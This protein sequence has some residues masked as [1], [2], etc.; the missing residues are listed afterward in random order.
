MALEA[1]YQKKQALDPDETVASSNHLRFGFRDIR[2][3]K[4]LVLEDGKDAGLMLSLTQQPGIAKSEYSGRGRLEEAKSFFSNCS[5]YDPESGAILMQMSGLRFAKLDTG[6]KPDPHTFDNITWKPDITF[7]TQGQLTYLPT[8][9]G[10]TKTDM[11]VDLIT[12]KMPVL[13]VLE[14]TFDAPD[15]SCLWFEAGDTSSR[16]A[17]FEYTFASADAKSL[18]NAQTQH[19]AQRNS[20]FLMMSLERE[21]FGLPE[22]AYDLAI[23]KVRKISEVDMD[24]LVKNSKMLISD[25]GYMLFVQRSNQILGTEP[26]SGHETPRTPRTPNSLDGYSVVGSSTPASSTSRGSTHD[27]QGANEQTLSK[28]K[29]LKTHTPELDVSIFRDKQDWDSSKLK[30]LGAVPGVGSVLDI[31]AGNDTCAFLCTPKLKERETASSRNLCVA[32]LAKGTPSLTPF[33]RK[34]LQTSGWKMTEQKSSLFN[35]TFRRSDPSSRRTIDSSQWQALKNLI[36]SGSRLLWV[37]NGAQR[38]IKNPDNALAHG[39]FRVIRME[40]AN[41]KLTTLDVQ[42]NTSPA[43]GLA[44]VEL[45]NFLSNEESKILQETEFAERDGVLHIHRVVPNTAVN[46]FKQSEREGAQPMLRS[47]H[48]AEAAV[49]LRAERLGTFQSLTWCETDV[50]EAPVKEGKVEV[51]I[52][53]VG[54]NFKTILID[55]ASIGV[56]LSSIQ[57]AQKK[58]AEIYVTVGTEEKRNFLADDNGIPRERMFSCRD[59][60]FAKEIRDATNGRGIDVIINSLTG[61]MLEESWRLCADGGTFVEIGKKD[62]VDRN[63]LSMEP[64]D[65]NCS[66][67]AMDF[68]YTKDMSDSLISSIKPIY[69]ITTFGFDDIPAA[70]AYIRSGRHISQVV[71]TNRDKPNMQVPIRPAVRKLALRG[72]HSYLIVGGLKGLCGNLAIHKAQNGSRRIIVCSRSGIWDEASKKT[73]MNCMACRCQIVEAKGDVADMDFMRRLLKDAS[74]SIAGVA[75]GAMILMD[76][77]YET[78][79][80]EEYH[81]AIY[82]K[83]HGTWTLDRISLEQSQPLDFFTLLSSISGIVGKKGQSNYSAANTFLDAFASYRHSLGLGANAVDLGLIEDVGYVAEQGG[84]DSY[85]DKRQWTPIFEGWLRKILSYSILQQTLAPINPASSAQ[86]IT[87]IRFPLPDDSD[88]VKEA[89]FGYLFAQTASLGVR[90]QEGS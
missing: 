10:A 88:L 19:E 90:G 46:D 22:S 58:D 20:S 75:Q 25:E 55:S 51:K 84:M 36:D 39:L 85:F 21:A 78:K 54:A 66:F 42:S 40:A 52:M 18:I 49:A 27:L 4:A 3:D 7:L 14:I 1:L 61:E 33:L 38:S 65:R 9:D 64:F 73:A 47:L 70:L 15:A 31:P 62:I 67:R 71:I 87:G 5:V 37:T 79:T 17:Y 34:A 28:T 11:L 13:K 48:D 80:L 57:I 16:A 83:V 68:S 76:K 59:K 30:S 32:R 26:S 24:D 2:F 60:R 23:V 8:P 63:S 44:I 35:P 72:D 45:L 29:V 41:A 86:L 50:A 56:G 53:A 89:R 77:P 82:G 81:T 43:T 74:P 6:M 12:H 69:P